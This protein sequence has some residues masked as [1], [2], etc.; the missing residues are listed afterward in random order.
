MN[1]TTE[2]TNGTTI[3]HLNGRFDASCTQ[4]FKKAIK[5]LSDRGNHKYII[6]FGKVTFIDSG[7]LGSL[8]SSLRRIREKKGD[9]KIAELQ[10]NIR[11]VFE[12][13]RL[14]RI[15]EIFDDTNIAVLTF[16]H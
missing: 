3:I 6:D 14:H 10:P 9:I 1:F 5:T 8:V 12:L 15:F 4:T 13:T 11:S 2:Y 16:S 7:G